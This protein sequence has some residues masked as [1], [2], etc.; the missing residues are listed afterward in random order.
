VSNDKCEFNEKN[1]D[2]LPITG[3]DGKQLHVCKL[4]GSTDPSK[5]LAGCNVADITSYTK[6]ISSEHIMKDQDQDQVCTMGDCDKFMSVYGLI[7]TSYNEKTGDCTAKISCKNAE[8]TKE[9]CDPDTCLTQNPK[10]CCTDN[11]KYNGLVCPNDSMCINNNCIKGWVKSQDGSDCITIPPDSKNQDTLFKSYSKCLSDIGICPP[12]YESKTWTDGDNITYSYGKCT[13]KTVGTIGNYNAGILTDDP[14]TELYV[15]ADDGIRLKSGTADDI[16][17]KD[18]DFDG[19]VQ[20]Y[21]DGTG[22][23]AQLPGSD[24]CK[25]Q[26][27]SCYKFSNTY[28]SDFAVHVSASYNKD[29]SMKVGVKVNDEFDTPKVTSNIPYKNFF[30][31]KQKDE[32]APVVLL[33]VPKNSIGERINT[34]NKQNGSTT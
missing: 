10:Q 1:M 17:G 32:R 27:V 26:E 29:Q 21:R 3:I 12:G 7:D 24:Y 2:P 16:S 30:V 9:K 22:S 25:S 5:P 14:D 20:V 11:N 15:C 6:T 34:E 28:A 13:P 33:G 18:N 31:K 4:R 23:C 19:I 8:G